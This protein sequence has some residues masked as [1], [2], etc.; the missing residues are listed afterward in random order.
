MWE[1]RS[2]FHISVPSCFGKMA[3]GAGGPVAQRR[4]RSV[5]AS[6]MLA[7]RC[8]RVKRVISI[9]M[10]H[11]QS[12]CDLWMGISTVSSAV[13]ILGEHIAHFIFAKRIWGSG[14]P[15]LRSRS[16]FSSAVPT[17]FALLVD[18]DVGI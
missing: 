3:C 9:A 6:L 5:E 16:T 17:F 4:V 11:S 18:M 8:F 12:S 14:I 1:T 10:E 7:A 15:S 2:V 13:G